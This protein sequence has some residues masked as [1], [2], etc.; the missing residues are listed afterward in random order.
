MSDPAARVRR[1]GEFRE[2]V[3]SLID[4]AMHDGANG[5]PP[6][7]S[8]QTK[9]AAKWLRAAYRDALNDAAEAAKET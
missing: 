1:E 4:F 8:R 6:G 7:R 2:W 3:E 5:C 9:D